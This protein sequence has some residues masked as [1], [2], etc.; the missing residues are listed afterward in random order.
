MML[1]G[2]LCRARSPAAGGARQDD[3]DQSRAR[4]A[5]FQP[6]VVWRGRSAN[7]APAFATETRSK[8]EKRNQRP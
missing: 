1:F 6:T 4:P 2:V 7:A 5:H 3:R 8:A